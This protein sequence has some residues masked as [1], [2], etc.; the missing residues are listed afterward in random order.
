M[1][2]E[3]KYHV[4]FI[5]DLF[6]R[7]SK[8][9]IFSKVDLCY[10]YWKVC[11]AECDKPKTNYGNLLWLIWVPSNAAQL[12]ERPC[13]ALQP[14]EWCAGPICGC[15]LRQQHG[16]HGVACWVLAV[17]VWSNKATFSLC[18]TKEVWVWLTGNPLLAPHSRLW[19]AH[20]SKEGVGDMRVDS[21]TNDGKI[22]ELL[23]FSLLTSEVN[24]GLIQMSESPYQSIAKGPKMEVAFHSWRRSFWLSLSSNFLTCPSNFRPMPHIVLFKVWSCKIDTLL[25][26]KAGS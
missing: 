2:V 25:H 11:I 1:T 22:K 4:P 10:V 7:R 3:N 26:S 24:Q 14:Y 12:D 9:V 17:C 13:Y 15:Q 18:R 16:L 8:A 19:S 21:T 20:G 6:D 23:G 5:V